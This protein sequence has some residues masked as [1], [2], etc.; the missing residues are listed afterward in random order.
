MKEGADGIISHHDFLFEVDRLAS[1]RPSPQDRI[2]YPFQFQFLSTV[3]RVTRT[4]YYPTLNQSA[5][6][7]QM[8]NHSVIQ[9]DSS[10]PFYFA[11]EGRNA[12]LWIVQFLRSRG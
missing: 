4:V 11:E 10:M 8:I 3:H 9:R 2:H 5:L 12:G 6:L 7:H 1:A